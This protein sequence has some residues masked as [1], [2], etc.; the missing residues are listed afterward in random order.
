[1]SRPLWTSHEQRH[2]QAIP[3][4]RGSKRRK[5]LDFLRRKGDC[6]PAAS[7]AGSSSTDADQLHQV[8]RIWVAGFDVSKFS[9]KMS[10]RRQRNI[11]LRVS[12]GMTS[13]TM[14]SKDRGHVDA[15]SPFQ[16]KSQLSCSQKRK[17][18]EHAKKTDHLLFVISHWLFDE[19]ANE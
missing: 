17:D 6:F 15:R 4:P 19:C 12:V 18:D 8:A 11:P 10:E 16:R 2:H 7:P 1:M 9:F 13:H 5:G 3:H 14:L